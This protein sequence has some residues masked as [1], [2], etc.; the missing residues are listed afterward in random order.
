MVTPKF[1]VGD[2]VMFRGRTQTCSAGMAVQHVDS[3]M[4][5]TMYFVDYKWWSEGNLTS[6][7]DWKKL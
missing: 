6:L 3:N 7:E 2:L 5:N 4:F 1:S